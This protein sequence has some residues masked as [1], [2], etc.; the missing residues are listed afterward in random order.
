MSMHTKKVALIHIAVWLALLLILFFASGH[1]RYV[2]SAVVVFLYGALNISLFYVQYF[3]INPLFVGGHEYKRAAV[4]MIGLLILSVAVKYA[5]ALWFASF[6]LHY[7]DRL[8]KTYTPFQYTAAAAIT[9]LL[10]MML[11]LATYVIIDNFVQRQHRKNLENEKLSAELAFLKSQL[12]PHFLFNSLNNI[13]ALAYLKSDKA[14]EA[15]LKLAGIMRY[16]LYESNEDTVSLA[17]EINYLRNYI[18]LQKLRVKE[19]VFVVLQVEIDAPENHRIMPL[20]LISFLE[21]AFKHG[22]STDAGRPIRIAMRLTDNQLHFKAENAKNQQNKDQTPGVGLRNLR[23][24]LQ[25]GY[26]DRHTVHVVE[27]ADY[28]SGE[29]LLYL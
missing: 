7:G 1:E 15:I 28:Y 25:L 23:R 26:P 13:Y 24:R 8:D 17:D 10:F 22:V 18:E 3:L 12:N 21:N 6:I 5:V 11:S 29:L 2:E 9:S 14:P 16:M 27:S 4:Y 19:E 20:L